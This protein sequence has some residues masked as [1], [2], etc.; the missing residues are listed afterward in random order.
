LTVEGIVFGED[1]FDFTFEFLD[2]FVLGAEGV[3][4]VD[5]GFLDLR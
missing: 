2:F 4:V 1:G 3:F 5:L